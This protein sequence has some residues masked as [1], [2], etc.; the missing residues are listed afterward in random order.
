[1]DRFPTARALTEA[2]A[3][4]VR[5]LLEKRLGGL[6]LSAE[7]RG[8]GEPIDSN[9]TPAGRAANRRVDIRLYP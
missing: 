2:R 3:E 7:G 4:A 6:R 8:D 5:A 9:D 1:T